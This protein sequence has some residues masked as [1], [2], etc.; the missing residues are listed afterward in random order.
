VSEEVTIFE[1]RR[2]SQ[3]WEW[4][5]QRSVNLSSAGVWG[6]LKAISF[7]TFSLYSYQISELTVNK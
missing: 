6:M 3:I 5:V 2:N 7:L 4:L 1:K